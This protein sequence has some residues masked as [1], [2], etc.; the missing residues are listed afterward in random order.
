[1]LKGFKIVI[2]LGIY[3]VKTVLINQESELK[4]LENI[5]LNDA[6]VFSFIKQIE[7][8]KETVIACC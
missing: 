2:C 7:K 5:S 8:V 6:C 3:S 1:M 4:L